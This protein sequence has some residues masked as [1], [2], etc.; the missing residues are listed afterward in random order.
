ML[1]EPFEKK[2]FKYVEEIINYYVKYVG[3]YLGDYAYDFTIHAHLHHVKQ[4][5]QHGPLKSHSQFVFEVNI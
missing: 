5:K 3:I 1:Y 2:K 4:V